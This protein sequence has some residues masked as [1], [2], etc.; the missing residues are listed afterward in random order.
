MV[1]EYGDGSVYLL[2]ENRQHGC[3]FRWS[4]DGS[5]TARIITSIERCAWLDMAGRMNDTYDPDRGPD[6]AAIGIALKNA[7]EWRVWGIQ[8]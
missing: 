3:T 1:Q 8:K 5:D 2:Y 4:N 6:D 7:D